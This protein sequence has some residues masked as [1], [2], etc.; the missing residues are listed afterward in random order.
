NDGRIEP[1]I[2]FY[3]RVEDAEKVYAYFKDRFDNG[4]SE[5]DR[6]MR[7]AYGDSYSYF[8]DMVS[9]SSEHAHGKKNHIDGVFDVLRRRRLGVVFN[10]GMFIERDKIPA[11]YNVFNVGGSDSF[12][13]LINQDS[14]A[15]LT[16][17]D[18]KRKLARVNDFVISTKDKKGPGEPEILSG[19]L[20]F[21]DALTP[22]GQKRFFG[23]AT[24]VTVDMDQLIKSVHFPKLNEL[25]QSEQAPKERKLLRPR[26]ALNEP[27]DLAPQEEV[28][29]VN[30]VTDAPVSVR[31]TEIQPIGNQ[32][33]EALEIPRIHAFRR[34]GNPQFDNSTEPLREQRFNTSPIQKPR[35]RRSGPVRYRPYNSPIKI[36]RY[37]D[38]SYGKPTE[39]KKLIYAQDARDTYGEKT[40]EWRSVPEWQNQIVTRVAEEYGKR[41]NVL[42]NLIKSHHP[43]EKAAQEQVMTIT[44]GAEAYEV[45][46]AYKVDETGKLQFVIHKDAEEFLK[47]ASFAM[48]I[49]DTDWVMETGLYKELG[50]DPKVKN[51]GVEAFLEKLKVAYAAQVTPQTKGKGMKIVL[52][53]ASDTEFMVSYKRPDTNKTFPQE[54]G[55]R[56]RYGFCV[57]GKSMKNARNYCRLESR[58]EVF[59]DTTITEGQILTIFNNSR[60]I[61]GELQ[62]LSR[63][64]DSLA[65]TPGALVNLHGLS[66]RKVLTGQST[67]ML[68]FDTQD[69]LGDFAAYIEETYA[70]YVDQ[71]Y[72]TANYQALSEV[73]TSLPADL[74]A[75][76]ATAYT[77][78]GGPNKERN[79]KIGGVPLRLVERQNIVKSFDNI[80]ASDN[81]HY[82]ARYDVNADKELAVSKKDLAK[83]PGL[84]QRWVVNYKPQLSMS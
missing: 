49:H 84:V 55:S 74:L 21:S 8:S 48:L 1:T 42:A 72:Y 7:K 9:S 59:K 28:Q 27:A 32:D 62:K 78:V 64:Y 80:T 26:R 60:V 82:N 14:Q 17:P 67:S 46:T 25:I 71:N 34:L 43:P 10:V 53:D 35:Q 63:E 50:L 18:N 51:A 15:S 47:H 73:E 24:A 16:D 58:Y 76:M 37:P 54:D 57:H 33:E 22:E 79:V 70:N 66:A 52:D 12:V 5:V 11:I 3:N 65:S 4:K 81:P 30:P 61:E 41:F 38:I 69:F 20:T 45:K 36:T 31:V 6:M 23:G 2:M 40:E 83:L 56:S 29:I 68:A 77:A 75:Q 44:V 13:K 39:L 19:G